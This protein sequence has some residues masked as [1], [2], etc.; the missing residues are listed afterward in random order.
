MALNIKPSVD[1]KEFELRCVSA[2]QTKRTRE[3]AVVAAAQEVVR[4]QLE[5]A[6]EH[7]DTGRFMRASAEAGNAALGSFGGRFLLPPIRQSKMAVRMHRI[8]INQV[9]RWQ[10]RKVACEK[11][12]EVKSKNYKRILRMLKRAREELAKFKANADTG[13]IMIGAFNNSEKLATVRVNFAAY[14]GTGTVRSFGNST[15]VALHNK[16][17]HASIVESR[18]AI[19]RTAIRESAT[20]RRF[21]KRIYLDYLKKSG[22]KTA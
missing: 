2:V 5:L 16:E 12:G 8:L 19:T 10:R 3:K 6:S 20:L 1:L 15:I 21:S 18:F 11:R 9:G 7:V 17:P 14:G 13:V 4:R 22:W